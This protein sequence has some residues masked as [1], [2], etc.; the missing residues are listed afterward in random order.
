MKAFPKVFP[1]GYG[2]PQDCRFSMDSGEI[3]DETGRVDLEQY[4][5]HIANLSNP[6]VHKSLFTLVMFNVH[7]KHRW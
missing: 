1:Y 7:M 5:E 6:V 2:G 4:I 3:K